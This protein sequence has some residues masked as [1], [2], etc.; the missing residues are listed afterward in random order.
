MRMSLWLYAG[1]A[2]ALSTFETPAQSEEIKIGAMMPLTRGGQAGLSV[3]LGL[4]LAVK[5][6]NAAGGIGG[7][8]VKLVVADTQGDPTMGVTEAKRLVF[9]EKVELVV[10]PAYSA[11]TIAAMPVLTSAKIAS[12]NYSGS[13]KLTPKFGLYSFSFF[14]DADMQAKLMFDYA[15]D[16]YSPKTI[17]IL[18]DNG[19]FAR[20]AVASIKQ[21]AEGAQIG[22]GGVQEYEL[23]A[24]DM[25]PQLLG[26]RQSA[27]DVVLLSASNGDDTGYLLKGMREIGWTVPI[28][29]S[30]GSTWATQAMKIAGPEAYA[31]LVGVNYR[32]FTFCAGGAPK[33]S[34]TDFYD[35]LN[36]EDPTNA[37]L[38]SMTYASIAYDSLRLL[39][40]AVEGSGG[41][42]DGPTI[43]SWIEAN[44][45]TFEGVNSGLG[46]SAESH[47]LIGK[48]A[49]AIVR[50]DRMGVA[51]SQELA[52]NCAK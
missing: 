35:R 6:I 20:T 38:A 33:Q 32:A 8:Q 24:K 13:A 50:P 28:V 40:A 42:T 48:N 10:G 43:A 5:E 30:F 41:K 36:K 21:A 3:R 16:H 37:P 9:N 44:N 15:K 39:K 34:F 31:N 17:A 1:V 12:I 7:R 25:T 18:G 4:D 14:A 27:P 29:G 19:E 46:A 52:E 23:G 47:W 11:V 45:G 49:L 22:V 51:G 26:L 2:L